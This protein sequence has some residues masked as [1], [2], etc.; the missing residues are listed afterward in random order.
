MDHLHSE[1]TFDEMKVPS[2]T[3]FNF[4]A[5][6]S[7]WNERV[8]LAVY[9]NRLITIEPDYERYGIT[10]RRYSSPYFGMEVNIKI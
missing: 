6:K 3:T 5:T 7:F 9:V 1:A 10:V 4:K 2:S 8:A